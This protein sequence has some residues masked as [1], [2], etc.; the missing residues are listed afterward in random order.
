MKVIPVLFEKLNDGCFPSELELCDSLITLKRGSCARIN[1]SCIKN[2]SHDVIVPNCTMLGKLLQVRPA[3][4]FQVKFNGDNSKEKVQHCRDIA[5]ENN[6]LLSNVAQSGVPQINLSEKIPE[7]KLP[8]GLSLEQKEIILKEERGTSEGDVGIAEELQM[9][10][11]L[12][13]YRPA[14]KNY[15]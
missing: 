3:T 2:S 12:S 11:N 15:V 14:E 9:K 13:D 6:S 10:I 5:L 4:P 1:A 8:E 7:V